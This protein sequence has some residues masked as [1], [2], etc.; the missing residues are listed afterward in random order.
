MH[1]MKKILLIIPSKFSRQSSAKVMK[2]FN[3]WIRPL[4]EIGTLT[5]L[6]NFSILI[7]LYFRHGRM[8]VLYGSDFHVNGQ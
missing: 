1:W 4:M 6:K 7:L 5:Y 8:Q 2:I 3:S